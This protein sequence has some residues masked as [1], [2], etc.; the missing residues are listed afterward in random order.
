MQRPGLIIFDCDGVLVNT[1]PIVQQVLADWITKH[2]W[3]MTADE[4]A[5]TVKGS[6][7]AQ[8]Q[9]R[10]EER[11]GKSYPDFIE[12]YRAAMFEA[13]E[14]GVDEIP[15]AGAVLR[16]LRDAGIPFCIASNGPHVKMNVTMKSAGLLGHFGGTLDPNQVFS[17]DDVGEP[18]PSPKLFLHAAQRMGFEPSNCVVIDDSHQGVEA[19]IAAGMTIIGYED[20]TPAAKLREAGAETVMSSLDE[21]PALLGI[22]L[23]ARG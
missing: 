21:L 1:E 5:R 23:A 15:S 11:T 4:C 8:I 3:P 22:D 19:A 2:G 17:A 12:G 6:H 13:F 16:T 7:I 9:T 10:V 20:M 14:S 18:K